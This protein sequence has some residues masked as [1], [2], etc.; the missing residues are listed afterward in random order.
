MLNQMT[1]KTK[2]GLVVLTGL[3]AL[4]VLGSM[5][6]LSL[7]NSMLED[8]RDKIRS[9][10]E[11]VGGVI[12][13]FEELASTGKMPEEEAKRLA[14]DVIGKTNYNQSEYVFVQDQAMNW[15][16]HPRKALV[17]KNMH[18][19]KD[20]VG[21]DLGDLFDQ[22]LAAHPEGGFA[23]YV[24]KKND[25]VGNVAKISYFTLSPRWK[26]VHGTGIYLDDVNT[27]FRNN[28]IAIVSTILLGLVAMLGLGWLI[29]S[30]LVKELGGEPSYAA[31][32]VKRIAEG[33]LQTVV[34]IKS[35]DQSSLLASIYEM[36]VKLRELI[37]SIVSNSGELGKM[38]EDISMHAD[39]TA[40]SSEEQSAAAT[41]MAASIEEMT[42]SINH[43]ADNAEEARN[44][45]SE[46]GA[47]ANQG[48]EVISRAVS[49]MQ[50]ISSAVD[51]SAETITDLATRTETISSIT[52]VIK[53]IADQTNLLAL[54]A[55][56]EAARAGEQGRGFAVVADE[57]RKLAERTSSATQEISSMITDIQSSSV[58]SKD[59]MAEAVERV[60][61]GAHLAEEGGVAVH[62]IHDG[63]ERVVRV[64]NDISLSLREQS[65]ASN[66]IALNVEK[67]AQ[68]AGVNAEVSR[69]TAAATQ[70]MRNMTNDLMNRVKRFRI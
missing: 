33:D 70:R 55:A 9:I 51:Q 21:T 18:G 19:V 64:V 31:E 57:V 28:A 26:W 23:E 60:R 4:I 45:S 56:I 35:G 34:Q 54:N 65:Q 1:M 69:E 32:V 25:E 13:H 16:Q 37:F 41:S 30:R 46:S 43:I 5:S 24:W 62:S 40:K 39:Q 14:L 3:I 12:R 2:L 8:R 48:A 63:T 20:G 36:Q 68:C 58:A 10:T 49:E 42:V 22:V 27:Q 47:L 67:I 15:L 61:V 53:E 50:R 29:V 44:R 6:L 17:G 38:A 11:S 52:N 66:D 7:R 59:N